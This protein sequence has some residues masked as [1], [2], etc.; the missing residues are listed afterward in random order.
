MEETRFVFKLMGGEISVLVYDVDKGY[1]EKIMGDFYKEGLRLQKIFNFFDEESELSKLNRDR[2][3]IVSNDLLKVIKKGLVFSKLTHGKYD[4]SLGKKFF[5]RKKLG[6]EIEI[7]CSFRDINIVGNEVY[8]ENDEVMVDLGS[9]AKGYITDRLADFLKQKRIEE[10]LIDS[11]GDI[12]IF[13]NYEHIL[14]VQHPRDNEKA[15]INIKIKN[16]G[17]ATSGDYKQFY[18]DFEKSHILNANDSVSISVIA[19]SVEDADVYATALF[20]AN[21]K[22]KEKI[23]GF[24]KKVKSLIINRALEIKM[25]NNFEEVLHEL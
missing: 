12:Y 1:I 18:G 2:K 9:I 20:V 5:A 11:R 23:M 4:I 16:K 14:G 24:D 6:K 25:Y 13:G 21:D 19:D 15:I 10:F 7:S 8:L 3:L 22:E 17:V